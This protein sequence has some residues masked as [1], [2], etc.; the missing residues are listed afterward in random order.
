MTPHHAYKL[1]QRL[2][3]NHL[4]GVDVL[5]S[6]TKILMF[7]F[8]PMFVCAAF[9]SGNPSL[10]CSLF[11]KCFCFFSPLLVLDKD[12]ERTGVM[13]DLDHDLKCEN[14]RPPLLMA[15]PNVNRNGRS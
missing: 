3:K 14:K 6:A 13:L 15:G 5:V 4:R 10:L 7:F 2:A 11:L 8:L 9:E 12:C 1:I